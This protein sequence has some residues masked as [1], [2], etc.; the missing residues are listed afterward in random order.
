MRRFG[1]KFQAVAVNDDGHRFSS[2]LEYKYC[3]YLE[4]LQKAGEVVFFLRQVPFHLPGGVKYVCDFAVFYNDGRCD[5]VD[6]K[7]VET[8]EFKTKKRLVEA[9]YPVR[10]SVI[11]K[12]DF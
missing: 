6:I 12:E 4:L 11:R 1:H 5:F 9:I 8:A 3:K 7:G 10:I 2:K